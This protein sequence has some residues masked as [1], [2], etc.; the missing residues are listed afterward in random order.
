MYFAYFH[1]FLNWIKFK[2]QRSGLPLLS[3]EWS[4]KLAHTCRKIEEQEVL[5]SWM[6]CKWVN[7]IFCS[8]Y[9]LLWLLLYGEDSLGV[10]HLVCYDGSHPV[11]MHHGMLYLAAFFPTT[12]QNSINGSKK[13]MRMSELLLSRCEVPRAESHQLSPSWL[14]GLRMH[15]WRD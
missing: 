4:L 15:L 13:K 7:L 10:R 6:H 1:T 14:K 5:Y 9:I 2:V 11:K 3:Q 8:V 12:R